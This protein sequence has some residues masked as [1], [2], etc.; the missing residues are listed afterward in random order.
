ME[1]ALNQAKEG[2]LHIL[3][4]MNEA[5]SEARPN[6][7]NFAP[8]IYTTKIPTDKIGAVIGPGGK[9]I[10]K[11][12][13]D[14]NVEI[15]IE[16]DGTVSISGQDAALAKEAKEYI[17]WLTAE[18]EIGKTYS[19]RVAGVKEFGAFVEFLPGTQGL[20]HIS[21]IDNKRVNKVSDVLKEGDT[22]K[23]KL[24]GIEGGKFSLSRK[25]LLKDTPPAE[26]G[27]TE[28]AESEE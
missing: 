14:F 9:V 28:T 23:V 26:E 5:I 25:V 12:Q 19:G 17:K 10:Q 24:I 4:I 2:R 21:Q 11:M 3:K 6:I 13:R 22:I 20:L 7:S 18:P 27:K 1:K 15:N 16:E 8:R